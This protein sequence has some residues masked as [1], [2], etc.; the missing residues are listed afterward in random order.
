MAASQKTASQQAQDA[1]VV[2]AI[3]SK[4]GKNAYRLEIDEFIQDNAVTNL[5]L[6]ALDAMYKNSLS[7][8]D[9]S[10]NWWSYYSLSGIHGLPRE[11]WAG[12]KQDRNSGYCH[13]G[14]DTFPTWHRPYMY[15][16]EQAV[17]NNMVA[18]AQS[19][20]DQTWQ[21]TYLDACDRFRLPYWD[22][23]MPRNNTSD[24]ATAKVKAAKGNIWRWG[25]P[26]VLKTKNVFVRFPNSPDQLTSM[27]NPLYQFSFPSSTEVK[28]AGDSRSQIS[29]QDAGLGWVQLQDGRWKFDASRFRTDYTARTPT[30]ASKGESDYVFLEEAIQL[31]TQVMATN[32]W[33]LLN[34]AEIGLNQ[35]TG[36]SV[37][38]NQA[39]PWTVFA[40]HA[41]T[42]DEFAAQSLESWHDNIHNLVGSGKGKAGAMSD[43]SV[44]AFEPVFWL[45]H[46]NIDRL[47]AIFQALY[48][49]KYVTPGQAK[50]DTTDE[51]GN[52]MVLGADQLY[53]F[54]ETADGACYTSIEAA[55][56]DW[57]GTGFA[58]P[59][60]ADLNQA[61]RDQVAVYLRDTYYWATDAAEPPK[62]LI[63][64]KD[65]SHVEALTGKSETSAKPVAV[66][67]KA[68]SMEAGKPTLVARSL[69]A[70]QKQAV[71]D[72][73]IDASISIASVQRVMK[74]LPSGASQPAAHE[75][76]A[77][78]RTWNINLRVKK[79][80]FN[81][82]FNVHFFI[83]PVDEDKS[84]R[85]ITRMNEVGFSG[86]FASKPGSGCTNCTKNKDMVYEDTVPLTGKLTEYLASSPGAG[87]FLPD[88]RTIQSLEVD[89]V[90]P[91]LKANL[92]WRVVDTSGAMLHGVEQ[93]GLEI[94]VTD[95][96]FT[97]PS[98][99][100]PLGTYEAS[101]VHS[102]IT[103]GK[104]GGFGG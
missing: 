8:K 92:T 89:Q 91:F 29:W 71:H 80:A 81:G 22:V 54:R 65:L 10:P 103:A 85:F 31:Q 20:A 87:T 32:I 11:N 35:M 42:S 68:M 93:S 9:G 84:E 100:E 38:I 43:P 77:K 83:G 26:K 51:N 39:K 70:A 13:H 95:R 50:R 64:P 25:F 60:V 57:K 24:G 86:I 74:A 45:H 62:T 55:V 33:H 4:P 52:P 44:A 96:L 16:F 102:E 69:S 88:G 41:A 37:K 73:T 47:F 94:K 30:V 66:S 99:A 46:N 15:Q 40:S 98:A 82:S 1:N 36:R 2:T 72:V 21:K 59:G 61:G 17:Y 53:P 76:P 5:F 75:A 101:E 97:P 3:I 79:Y 58:V 78:M 23:C 63:W 48:P 34:P 90:V 49:D 67:I 18:I 56:R 27:A 14:M 104:V 6:L 7:N 12:I 28:T 19:Y